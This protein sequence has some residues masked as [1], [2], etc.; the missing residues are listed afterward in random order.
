MD[1]S[2]EELHHMYVKKK[3]IAAERKEA[4][5]EINEAKKYQILKEEHN[6]LQVELQLF[7]L[8]HIQKDVDSLQNDFLKRREELNRLKR[9]KKM[10]VT[11]KSASCIMILMT[12]KIMIT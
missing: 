2:E 5:G 6:K 10:Q 9:K 3:G 12:T 8:Y 4:V 1:R 7:K 11:K